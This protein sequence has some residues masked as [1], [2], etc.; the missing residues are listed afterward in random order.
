M[1]VVHHEANLIDHLS[2][3]WRLPAGTMETPIPNSRLVYEIA[4]L[5]TANL[6]NVTVEEGRPVAFAAEA[7]EFS[8]AK[9]SVAEEWRGYS[10]RD[11]SHV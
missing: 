7:G 5:I 8:A 1:E 2:V 9:F 4:P 3:Q 10:R 6:T 11:E